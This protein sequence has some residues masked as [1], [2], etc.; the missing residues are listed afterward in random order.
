MQVGGLI[1]ETFEALAERDMILSERVAE[2]EAENG[3]EVI[4]ESLSSAQ[5]Q[6]LVTK[7]REHLV[8]PASVALKE[9]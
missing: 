3:I 2:L 8:P 4:E 1:V 9:D 6:E 5:L 7:M